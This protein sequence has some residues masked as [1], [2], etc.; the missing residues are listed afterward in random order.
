MK[1]S[2]FSA[3]QIIKAGPYHLTEDEMLQF[4]RA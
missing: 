4:A 2:E 1:F 3:G